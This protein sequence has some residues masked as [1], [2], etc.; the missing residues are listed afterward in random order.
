MAFLYLGSMLIF[1]T[2]LPLPFQFF[3][4]VL[5]TLA[6]SLGTFEL[7]RRVKVLRFLFGVV[8]RKK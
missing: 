4:L 7:V 8:E 1:S 2:S 3:L 5:F 6:G